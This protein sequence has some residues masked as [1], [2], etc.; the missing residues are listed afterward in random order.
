MIIVTY[1]SAEVIGDCLRSVPN[2]LKVLVIDNAS[3]DEGPSMVQAWADDHPNVELIR[4]DLN[5]GFGRANNIGLRRCTTDFALLLN[6][7][8]R[9]TD[10][11]IDRLLEISQ[12]TDHHFLSPELTFNE[13]PSLPVEQ[14]QVTATKFVLGAFLM[15]RMDVWRE[16][17]F[18]DENIFMYGEDNELCQRILAHGFGILRVEGLY[19]HHIGGTNVDPSIPYLKFR[20]EYMAKGSAYKHMHL[21]GRD[22][23]WLRRKIK[24]YVLKLIL[25][26]LIFD[27]RGRVTHYAKIKGSLDYYQRGKDS[28]LP[29]WLTKD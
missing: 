12:S 16:T 26:T 25:A 20:H 27:R 9:L 22:K 28:L 4:N 23:K 29:E 14:Q 15:G 6:P 11:V 17:G 1:N 5:Q 19:A 21:N 2:D 10:G 18:F 13:K 7:D 3:T 8:A 24:N